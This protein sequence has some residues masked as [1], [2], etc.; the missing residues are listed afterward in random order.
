MKRKDLILILVV[1]FVSAVVALLLSRW[2]FSSPRN[3]EQTAEKVDVIVNEFTL[4]SRTYFNANSVNPTT[5]IQIGD[6]SNPNPFN[7]QSE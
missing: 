2:I 6:D 5:Q 4:P 1:A 7:P 3:R